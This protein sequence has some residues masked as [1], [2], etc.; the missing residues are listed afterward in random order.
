MRKDLLHN[1]TLSSC[2]TSSNWLDETPQALLDYVHALI[3]LLE[4]SQDS[5]AS[6]DDAQVAELLRGVPILIG[7]LPA[8]I[9]DP[10]G[11]GQSIAVATMIIGL[12]HQLD[13]AALEAAPTGLL[14]SQ[15]S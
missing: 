14:S 12:I 10:M 7:L 11:S 4:L 1:R 13:K 2:V 15:R 5:G 6:Q 9:R 3:R 8:S